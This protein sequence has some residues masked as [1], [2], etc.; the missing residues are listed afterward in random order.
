ML[1]RFTRYGCVLA[2]ALTSTSVTGA[3]ASPLTTSLT[4]S[5]S[6]QKFTE[7]DFKVLDSNKSPVIGAVIYLKSNENVATFTDIEGIAKLKLPENAVVKVMYTGK[8]T[9]EINVGT[10]SLVVVTLADESLV[11]GEVVVVG[12]GK[13]KKSGVV[14]S[15]NTVSAKEIKLPT[16][17]LTNNLAGQM[18]GVIAI[19][20][21]GEP[22]Y[23]D[24]Q[25]FIRGVSSFAGGT[26]PLVLVDGVPRSMSD[27]G[28]DEIETFT[29]LKDASATAV[30]GAEGANGVV[31]ITTRR[32]KIG[33]PVIQFNAEFGI[34]SP[35]RVPEF[36]GAGDFMDGYNEARWNEGV[37]P[38]W[39]QEQI[40]LHRSGVDPDLYPDTN[41]MDM[42]KENT[43]NQRYNISFRGGT[44]KTRY[45]VAGSYYSED[46]IFKSESEDYNSNIGLNRY[47]LRSNI[48]IDVTESTLLRVNISG[49]YIESN[50]PGTG[51]QGIFDRMVTTPPN[52]FPMVYS[53][54]TIAAHPRRAGSRDNPYNLLMNSGYAKEW[55]TMLQTKIELEQKLNF[56]SKDL[57]LRAA[58][59]YDADMTF[60]TKRT[61]TETQYHMIGREEDNTP[62]YKEIY[63]GTDVLGMENGSNGQKRIYIE[64]ALDYAKTFKDVHDFSALLLYNQKDQQKHDNSLPFRKQNIVGRATY[65]YN[66]RYNVEANFGYTGSESFAEGYR[67]GLFPAIGASWVITNEKFI[68]GSQFNKIVSNLKIRASYGLT[69][70]DQTGG[71]R[72]LYRGTMNQE[73]GGFD[74]G[75]GSGGGR[76]GSGKGV[77]ESRFAAPYLAWETE[78]K[79]NVGIDIALLNNMFDV[80]VDAF[81][82]TRT[83]I[84]LQRRTVSSVTGFN[85]MPWQNFGVVRNKGIDASFSYRQSFGDFRLSARGTFTFARNEIIDYDEVPQ[86]HD[87]MNV[88]GTRL[89]EKNLYI[90]DGFYGYEDF[91][92]TGEGID[93]DYEL[94]EGVVGSGLSGNLRPG[95]LKYKDVNGDGTINNY[96]MVR[97]GDPD[98][99]EIVY[100]FG[101][102]LDYKGIYASVFFQG[103]DNTSM[104]ISPYSFMPYVGSV[105]EA[106]ARQIAVGN[107]WSDQGID[108]GTVTPLE[109]PLLPRLRTTQY[110]HNLVNSTHWQR[111]AWF[112]RLKNVELGYNLP[113]AML[114][115]VN[116]GSARIFVQ[117]HNLMVWDDIKLWDPELGGGKAGLAYPISS[118]VTFGLEMSF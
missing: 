69:G 71:D 86:K 83:D 115:K 78:E 39:S 12:Y 117:G 13:Q 58:V 54:G 42:M 92:I 110:D 53:D 11:I 2:I 118:S 51:T 114:S 93:R 103:A 97:S 73:A 101:F 45:F 63:S 29:V 99:P 37:S 40:D 62:I 84:L 22:G 8:S 87:W 33:K 49:Q 81:D 30:Y 26:S 48:D 91:N 102:S 104:I 31:L 98:V 76:G 57:K 24:A 1:S 74:M 44:E 55:R 28:V 20:R 90:A 79:F 16:R 35:T 15:I 95:D 21:N 66:S 36:M 89:N 72:F 105:D 64:A 80:T 113:K 9:Q 56:I 14:S 61:K 25:F 112:L 75:W 59:S 27:V 47:N 38:Q 77:V 17:N 5:K 60:S 50:Y 107:R 106:S 96:D 32:G 18:A 41:W 85:Q 108:G 68:K 19:Q 111:D 7:V 82:N 109:N 4:E 6:Q 65:S 43:T 116:I 88:T 46:G 10:K 34:L 100:G 52:L 67:F 70:N 3:L 94:K 23:D